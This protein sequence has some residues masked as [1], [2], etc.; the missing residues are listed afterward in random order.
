MHIDLAQARTALE[1]AAGRTADLLGSVPDGGLPAKRSQW[2]VGE[3]GAHLVGGLQVF[4]QAVEGSFDAV[5]PY[6]PD[7]E[8]FRDRLTAVTAGTLEPV[9]ERRPGILATL[10]LDAA[11][12]FLAAT[13]GRSPDETVRTSWYGSRASLSLAAATCL[14]AGEQIVHGYDIAHTVG[15][16]WPISAEDAICALPV[17][18]TPLAVNPETAHGHTAGSA[19]GGPSPAAGCWPGG[20]S[21]GWARRSPACSSTRKHGGPHG[22]DHRRG[23]Y[24]MDAPLGGIPTTSGASRGDLHRR[25]RSCRGALLRPAGPT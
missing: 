18:M 25:D 15:R 4:T 1:A 23:T 21:R 11:R 14:L 5:S 19:D 12:T 8:V 22:L 2:S 9:P 3:V 24:P 10:V 6:L 20:A 7:T 13:A 16:R 17:A